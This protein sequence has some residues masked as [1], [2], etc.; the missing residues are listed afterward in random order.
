MKLL[1]DECT[2]KRLKHDFHSHEVLTVDEV[3]LKGVLNGELL[4]AAIAQRFDVLI[5]VDRRIPFQQ[6]LSQFDIAVIILVAKPCRYAQLKMLVPQ[7][8]IVLETITAG[9]VVII[10]KGEP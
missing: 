2:P 4:R 9:D 6:D 3:G 5:T 1:L 8:I 7:A 10:Q